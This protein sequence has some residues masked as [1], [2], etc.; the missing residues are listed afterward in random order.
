MVTVKDKVRFVETDMMGV[1]H[2]S[3]FF[4]WFEMGRVEY[5]RQAGVFLLDLMAAGIL[6]PISDVSCHYRA[7]AR[8]DDTIAI[9]TTMLELSKV[10]MVFGYQVRR[11]S[12]GLL[13]A[14][15][16]TKNAFTDTDGKV[17]RL[18]ALYFDSLQALFL[19]EK[20]DG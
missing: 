14:T 16:N 3:N 18:P 9:E 7:S 12:D 13:L 11:E 2:H 8:F 4:R 5:L 17:I 6:F 15:G 1:V 10:K 19:Q 20:T